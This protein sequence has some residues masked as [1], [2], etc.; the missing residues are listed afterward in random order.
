[1][2][3]D[4]SRRSIVQSLM[5]S[6]G[7]TIAQVRSPAWSGQ[8]PARPQL[9]DA[10]CHVFNATDLPA[11]RFLKIV[12]ADRYPAQGAARLLEL[13]RQDV[14]DHLIDLMM[15]IVGEG[16]APTAAA[17]IA[18]LQGTSP[19]LAR[20]ETPEAATAFTARTTAAYL[21]RRSDG[22]GR[23]PSRSAATTDPVRSAILQAGGIGE[24]GRRA[25]KSLDSRAVAERAVKSATD[26]GAYLR[27]FGLFT[28][29]RYGL[30][31]ALAGIYS[32][33]GYSPVL[34]SPAI[35]DYSRW[36]GEEASS[37]LDDQ[38]SVMS[39]I[40]RRK[41]GPAVHGYVGFDPLREVYFRKGILKSGALSVVRSA[42]T[43]HGFAG[44][45]LYPPM[46]FRAS[47]NLIN[48]LY[49]QA[50][51]DDLGP[52]L[53]EGLNGALDDLYRLC[54]SL[55]APILV[56]TAETNGAG[57]NYAERADPAYWLPVL[58]EFPTLRLCLAHFGR[59]SYVSADA[60]SNAQLPESSWEWL[61]GRFLKAHPDCKVYVDL[62]YLTEIF[63][64]SDAQK[65]L[66]ATFRRFVAEFDPEVRHVIFGSDWVML[67]QDSRAAHYVE[68]LTSFLQAQCGLDSAAIKRVMRDNA[69]SFLG[70][71]AADPTRA[72]LLKFYK[73]HSLPDRLP[74]L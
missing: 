10:H 24:G 71:G 1:M 18:V 26:I 9:I 54:T 7:A 53:S 36:L 33:Q 69:L 66:G 30:V 28:L 74:M 34:L 73:A 20:R 50:V 32:D 5:A 4:L 29:Y 13:D 58:S 14:V 64:D 63:D 16:E 2:S 61:V 21:D 17:E 38:V 72:R 45:K 65:R 62:S 44:V 67:A 46:G 25:E 70:L 6:I 31:D 56:H 22:Q 35:I 3:L 15:F 37:S 12:I 41:R 11:R 55:D 19:K 23:G 48:Q 52:A 59:F 51:L 60:A 57:P 68:S 40:A 49:P 43:D 47:G 42:L 39:L 27:W 8:P